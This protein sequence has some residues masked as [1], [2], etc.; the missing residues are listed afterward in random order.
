MLEGVTLRDHI[1][2]LRMSPVNAPTRVQDGRVVCDQP[3]KKV[4]IVAFSKTGKHVRLLQNDPEWEIWGLNNGYELALFYDQQSRFRCDRWWELHPMA[5]QPRNDL[6]WMQHCPI[7]IYVLDLKD[8]HPQGDMPNAVQY[9]RAAV[10]A[11]FPLPVPY[12]ACTFAYQIAFAI[13]EGFTEIALLGLDFGTPREW[14]FERPNTLL[15]VGLAA[16]KGVSITVPMDSTLLWHPHAYGY[17]YAEEIAWCKGFIAHMMAQWG[18]VE[19][20]EQIAKQLEADAELA[21]SIP[22]RT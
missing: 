6:V 3:R 18:Y 17:D 10:E 21:A 16:G 8:R 19:T 14:I 13:L 7:P 2:N 20:P 11:Q 9:P 4:A 1:S 22:S 15:W 12:W 5:V